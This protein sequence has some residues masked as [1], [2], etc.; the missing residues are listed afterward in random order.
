MNLTD[1]AKQVGK[2]KRRRRVGHGRGS[3]RGKTCGRG[4][5]G[6]LARSGGSVG[7]T[8]EG[9]QMPISL[10]MPKR[11]FS[12]VKF[13]TRYALVNVGQL[14]DRFED[15]QTVNAERLV[16]AGL[17]RDAA[18]PVKVLA[19]GELSRRLTVEAAKFSAAAA[20]KITEA[21]GEATVV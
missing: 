15:G 20:R 13:R 4:E 14:Q 3:G 10:R 12:N 5:K 6:L 2:H 9:G 16:A 17:L 11:G 19:D 7:P 1:L 21:G 8:F 18:L